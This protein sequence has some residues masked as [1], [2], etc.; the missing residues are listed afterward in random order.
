MVQLDRQA[1]SKHF[2]PWD[3]CSGCWRICNFATNYEKM[4]NILQYLNTFGT[5]TIDAFEVAWNLKGRI[6]GKVY[7]TE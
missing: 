2:F 6:G 7:F 1:S 5:F 4:N 3:I